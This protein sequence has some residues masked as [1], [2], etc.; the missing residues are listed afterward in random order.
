[1]SLTRP[2]GRELRRRLSELGCREESVP[3]FPGPDNEDGPSIRR[4][5]NSR[6]EKSL[7]ARDFPRDD[8]TVS[9]SFVEYVA[10]RLDIDLDS[11]CLDRGDGTPVTV[12]PPDPPPTPE[13]A[14]RVLASRAGP[15]KGRK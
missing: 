9:P 10:R 2:S 8:E 7:P 11:L 1:M 14:P 5:V 13:P 15:K 3:I 6:N 12:R 4:I